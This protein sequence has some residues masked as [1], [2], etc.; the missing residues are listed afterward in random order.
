MLTVSLHQENCFPPGSGTVEER[1]EGAGEGTAVNVPLL[2]GGGHDAYM[3]TMRR[4]VVAS[5][6]DTN[7]IGPLGRIAVT[8]EGGY[9]ETCVPFC[10][11]ALIEVMCGHN[12][13]VEDPYLGLFQSQ[14]PTERFAAL[15]RGL[16][17]EMADLYGL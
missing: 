17:D 1:G 15:Q 14:Q 12:M 8:H 11:H 7:G 6:F 2:P 16:I 10:G 3:Y 5:G 13:G 9:A 4:I